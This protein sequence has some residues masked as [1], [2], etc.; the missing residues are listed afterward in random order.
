M[1]EQMPVQ[2]FKQ[3]QIFLDSRSPN[4]RQDQIEVAINSVGPNNS[5]YHLSLTELDMPASAISLDS[6]NLPYI[7]L[8]MNLPST[9]VSSSILSGSG[10]T[11]EAMNSNILAKIQITPGEDRLRY[12]ASTEDAALAVV[13]THSIENL[14]LRLT[15]AFNNDLS[16]LFPSGT[17]SGGGDGYFSATLRA[18]NYAY[19][20]EG[21]SSNRQTNIALNN[22]NI[23]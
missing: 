3:S 10:R 1:K 17:W 16:T 5:L 18:A 19:F 22:N 9:N 7:C 8:R 15:D 13:P 21:N 11:T 12:I 20:Y 6:L 23:M 4:D 2:L 14:H